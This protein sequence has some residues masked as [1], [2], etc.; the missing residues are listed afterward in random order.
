MGPL[1]QQMFP[2]VSAGVMPQKLHENTK[3]TPS[4]CQGKND[5]GGEFFGLG[6]GIWS[7]EKKGGTVLIWI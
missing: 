4:P 2:V 3:R 1:W 5:G 6:G 7:G